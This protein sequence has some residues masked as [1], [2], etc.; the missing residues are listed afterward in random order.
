MSTTPTSLPE[1]EMNDEIR[2]AVQSAVNADDIKALLLAE[3]QK[4][5]EVKAQ[6]QA[7]A[8]AQAV[9]DKVAA[10]KAA[11]EAAD[12]AAHQ[13][14]TRTEVIGGKA[15]EFEAASESELDRLVLQAY[16]V[17][18]AV[19]PDVNAPVVPQ[20]DAARAAQEAASRAEAEVAA[21]A[22]L[23]GQFK[24]GEI[25]TA[26]YLAKSGAISDYLQSNGI[27]ID[28][29]K[30]T[31]ARTEDTQ[32]EQ[33]WAEASKVFLNGIGAYW[34]GGERNQEQ[35]GLTI[36]H[37]GL[38]DAEDKVAALGK[39]FEYMKQKNMIFPNEAVTTETTPQTTRTTLTQA[40]VEKIAADAAAKVAAEFANR[41]T[42]TPAAPQR[43]AATSSGLFGRSSGVS[44]PVVPASGTKP[45]E[46]KH[47]IP[48]GTTPQEILEA[49]KA[50]QVKQGINPNDAFIDT[51][52]ARRS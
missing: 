36:A 21:K 49:W 15:F 33:S 48:A 27:S 25:S 39:A 31:V 22:E 11:A 12:A 23:E 17:A 45:G 19:R 29:L 10:D 32:Y 9:A 7:D 18:Y 14:Y 34:P 44:A 26:D 40:D 43:T 13:T 3:A 24:R 1:L 5:F 51:Y 6:T 38:T 8:D 50:E 47:E 35:I 41:G 16:Q 20:V 30:T 52:K 2:K 42:T 37:L 4:Q 28:A 46:V